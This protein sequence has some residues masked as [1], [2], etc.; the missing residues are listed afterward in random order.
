MEY[1]A[2]CLIKIVERAGQSSELLDELCKHGLIQQVTDLLSQNGRTTLSQPIYNVSTNF[3][4]YLLVYLSPFI[5]P[6]VFE[7]D[8][9]L[10]FYLAGLDRITCQT[11]FWF[12]CSLQEFV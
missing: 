6:I 11:F 3:H 7:D 1:V 4:P 2:T 12:I 10:L 9:S 8:I 5:F